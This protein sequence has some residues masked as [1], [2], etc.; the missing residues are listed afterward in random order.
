M[1]SLSGT[2]LHIT[3]L[4]FYFFQPQIEKMNSLRKQSLKETNWNW[5]GNIAR[6]KNQQF[7]FSDCNLELFFVRQRHRWMSCGGENILCIYLCVIYTIVRYSFASLKRFDDTAKWEHI[8]D[9]LYRRSCSCF[10]PFIHLDS[11]KTLRN[12]ILTNTLV[13]WLWW[14]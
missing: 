4:P 11:N 3:S 10:K 8:I 13:C 6:K 9:E 14:I 1:N 12:K 7:R 2:S 5:I